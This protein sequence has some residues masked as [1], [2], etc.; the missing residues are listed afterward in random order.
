MNK[1]KHHTRE[2]KPILCQTMLLRK[3]PTAPITVTFARWGCSPRIPLDKLAPFTKYGLSPYS[4]FANLW[5]TLVS[6]GRGLRKIHAEVCTNFHF[7]DYLNSFA[8]TLAKFNNMN[9]ETGFGSGFSTF[10]V[11]EAKPIS[12][13][14]CLTC[15][16]FSSQQIHHDPLSDPT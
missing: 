3:A 7:A 6:W 16:F 8:W 4:V 1:N 5:P 10:L 11:T 9:S 12:Q 13:C 15:F 14:G 2:W